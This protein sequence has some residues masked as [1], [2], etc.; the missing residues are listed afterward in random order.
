MPGD[1]P[2]TRLNP[3]VNYIDV[4]QVR[5]VLLDHLEAQ[6]VT[7]DGRTGIP[8]A[9]SIVVGYAELELDH[10]CDGLCGQES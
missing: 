1:G 6:A 5:R 10:D 8:F 4:D 3:P 9:R 2:G 7:I